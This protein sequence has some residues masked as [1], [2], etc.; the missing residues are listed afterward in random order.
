MP[1]TASALLGAVPAVASAAT[2][3]HAARPGHAASAATP[4]PAGS[5]APGGRAFGPLTSVQAARLSQGVDD[6]VIV[7]LRGQAGQATGG[8]A[9]AQ[10]GSPAVMA[11]QGSLLNEL[12]QVHATQIKRFTLV[13]S[14]AATVSPLEARRLAADP[15][16][17][18]V[19]PD[20]TFTVPGPA[21]PSSAAF[22]TPSATGPGAPSARGAGT[23][24]ATGAAAGPARST[25][26][27][28]NDIPGAC[29]ANGKSQLAP[30]GLSLTSTVSGNAKAPT[31]RSLGF[32]GAG[33][34]V[35]YIADGLD[36]DNVNFKR[37]NGQSVFT[38]YQDFTGNGPGA[39]TTGGEAFLDA[40]TIA[41]QGIAVYN[42][43]GFSAESYAGTTCDVRI[44]GVAPGASLVGLDVFSGDKDDTLV[45]TTSMFA[46]A[47]NYAVENA[48]VNVLN[49]SFG[50]NALPD[51][52]RD[53]IKLF[54]DAAVKAGVVVSASSG[55]AGT[56]NTIGS[57]ATDPN[58]ISVGATTQFQALAQANIG[59]TRYF[60]TKGWL[61]DNI[62]AF[63]SAGY[64]EA[65]GTVDMVAP[66][67]LSWASCDA[68]AAKYSECANDLGK[69][70]DI[71]EAGGTSE[72]APF[73]SGAAALVIQAF[74][75]T[76]GGQTPTPA[77]VKQ[78]LLSTAT[79]LGAPAQEQG[80]GL[81]NSYRAVQLAESYGLAKRTG[82]TLLASAGQ[83][84][85]AAVGGTKKTW[86]VT[87]TN[88]GAKAQTV[89][90]NGRALNPASTSSASGSVTLS[91][92]TSNQY[93]ADSGSKV[94]YQT[95]K[96]R[97]PAGQARLDVSIAYAA[98]PVTV[99]LPPSVALFDPDGRVAADSE[100]QG[101]AN[102]GNVEVRGPAAGVWTGVVS[103]APVGPGGYNGKVIWQE[104]TQ[105]YSSFGSVSP[106]SLSLAPGQAKSFNLSVTAPADPGDLAGSVLLQSP[107]D[108][109]T[110]IPVVV[111]SL[112]NVAG[113]GT[114]A[115]D[116][117]GGNGRGALG[118]GDY[119]Q[120]TV[121]SGAK[122]V[123][124]EL[125]LRDNPGIGNVAGAYLVGPDGNVMGY[126]QNSDLTGGQLGITDQTLT[127]TALNPD[128][129]TWTLI[130]AF[131]EPVAGTEVSDPYT[132]H[133]DF[134]TA[135]KLAPATPLP[136]GTTLTPGK[137]VTSPVTI[138]NASDAPQDYFLDPRLDTTTTVP[139]APV[140]P[141]PTTPFAGGPAGTAL[142]IL[143]SATTSEY[144]VPTLTSS[145]AVRQTSS[146]PA[147]TDLSPAV[148]GDPDVGIP[149][150]TKG[151][152]CGKSTSA[153]YTPSGGT[154]TSGLWG[155]EPTEC[156][157]YQEVGPP[158]TAT[159]TL[160]ATT[161]G[162]DRTVTVATG[163]LEQLALA[164]DAGN[165]GLSNAVEIQPGHSVTVNV[166]FR[167]AGQAGHVVDGT[168][169]LDTVQ[170]DVPPYGQLAADEVTAVPYS[171]KVG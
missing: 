124:A 142:P 77:Q 111:R 66:G 58:V 71:E 158:A 59:G 68:N 159:D 36:P 147:M 120:F 2:P 151:S 134:T 115:G 44:Q 153:T 64:D 137:A 35:G 90:L 52:A 76:H 85:D 152:L 5:A 121:P 75:K 82:S 50:G 112:I 143:A 113:G 56:A 128:A 87:V 38:D 108:G 155:P 135:G 54:D 46:Q 55:D 106:S 125:Q 103:G 31:A 20:A 114:F 84:T 92:A 16:V 104:A 97:V 170:S 11:S 118:T 10:A 131:G 101:V 21:A 1:A 63:S 80:A 102:Y 70:S 53:V 117:T 100:P 99:G 169:Y 130:L 73:V 42:V 17:A 160:T 146:L 98:D 150:L 110:S 32:T 126:G 154:V 139:L 13:N 4:T 9:P 86:K 171:Y 8:R 79:D 119:Y 122:A 18:Q 22:T 72:S 51:T 25:S 140:V 107:G 15:A 24:A 156:G 39:P 127:A 157:P 49:E 40:N 123:T 61:S 149:G 65:G 48:K 45:S 96:F 7:I 14:V 33:V 165:T 89:T 74:R 168:L 47:I 138:T 145:I 67:D 27:P 6:P 37:A 109:V 26:L 148:G 29:A 163:D 164:A 23:S 133:V 136:D 57:P 30:E 69:A 132:G 34:K 91:D 81:L 88:E 93:T 166:T 41:G 116:L 162:F 105:K 129:G 62:S 12:Q 78:I 141:G 19:V 3:A 167:A 161:A 60:A 83:L 144:F 94:N 43:N 95:F 28:L